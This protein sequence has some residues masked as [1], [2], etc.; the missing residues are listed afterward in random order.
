[1]TGCS[2]AFR[3]LLAAIICIAALLAAAAI[4][5]ATALQPKPRPEPDANAWQ[6]WLVL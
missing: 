6:D 5:I 1:M 3:T 2:R 4:E